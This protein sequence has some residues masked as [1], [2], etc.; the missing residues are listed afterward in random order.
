MI[1]RIVLIALIFVFITVNSAVIDQNIEEV[2]MDCTVLE[3]CGE[4][5]LFLFNKYECLTAN[6][7]SAGFGG[8]RGA[9]RHLQRVIA[10]SYNTRMG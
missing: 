10:N 3:A 9:I 1:C 6:K 4:E 5:C 2:P 8:K 7:R